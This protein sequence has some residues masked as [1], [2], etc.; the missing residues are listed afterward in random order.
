MSYNGIRV[1]HM[2]ALIENVA[3]L[4]IFG[5][6]GWFLGNR[7][8]LSSQNL[9]LLSVL[10]VWV[11]LPCNS[12]QTFSK[13]FTKTYIQ[14]RYPLIIVSVIVLVTLMVLNAVIIPRIIKKGGS[15]RQ[16]VLEYSLTVANFGYMGYPLIQGAYGDLMLLNAQVFALPMSIYTATEG[17]RLLTNAG[18]VS[19]KKV[20]SPMI[21]AI[22]IGCIFGLTGLQMPSV[23]SNVVSK[24]A[25]CMG[26]ISM[27]MAGITVSDYPLD[28]IF[29]DK[30]AYVVSFLRLLVIPLVL[31]MIL[32]RFCD[33]ET[34][35][36]AVLLYAMPCGLN[37]IVYPKMIGEDCRPGASMA[38]LSTIA[39]LLTIPMCMKAVEFFC[40]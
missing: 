11:F 22:F 17:Y 27:L 38:L 21:V 39:C 1:I 18:K 19:F 10:E 31:C 13:N 28:H 36:V 8:I 20:I 5:I 35:L 40:M 3:V 14:Q 7:K 32:S 9:K 4:L 37:T 25:A 34:V 33:R 6:I 26:P 16:H 30:Q 15:Y 12:L 23:L 24:G 2:Q 29:K